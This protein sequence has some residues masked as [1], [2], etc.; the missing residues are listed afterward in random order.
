MGSVIL[1][2]LYF[3][4]HVSCSTRKCRVRIAGNH[5]FLVRRDYPGRYPGPVAVDPAGTQPIESLVQGKPQPS[6]PGCD[7]R[8][9]LGVVLANAG[10]KNNAIDATQRSRE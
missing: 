9:C 6:A 1:A 7:R 10:G 3:F 2:T 8:S 4:P 5:P